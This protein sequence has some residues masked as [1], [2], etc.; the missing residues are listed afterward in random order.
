LSL[1]SNETPRYAGSPIT[2]T[3]KR[4]VLRQ[5]LYA[6]LIGCLTATAAAATDDDR[7]AMNAAYRE[8]QEIM[9][10][11]VGSRQEAIAPA[12]RAF[13]LA[14]QV[15]GTHQTTAA[16]G[17]NYGNLLQ[18][19]PVEARAVLT[20]A[21]E[22]SEAVHGK[23]ALELVDALL[24]LA[25]AAT[26]GRDLTGARAYYSHAL[27]IAQRHEPKD[28]LLQGI[29]TLNLGVTNYNDDKRLEAMRQFRAAREILAR[30]EGTL[31]KIRLATAD[32]W[33]GTHHVA[34]GRHKEAVEPLLAALRTFNEY[35][36]TR[37]TA[38]SNLKMLVEA[39]EAQGLREEATPHVIAVGRLTMTEPV[40]LYEVP[41]VLS[42]VRTPGAAVVSFTVDEQGYPV[43]PVI[44]NAGSDER[45]GATAL[46]TAGK[47]RY[48]PRVV[49]GV[50]VATPG[51]THMFRFRP[52]R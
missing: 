37:L 36:E 18:E 41:P 46:T 42:R 25:D 32:L 7:Q 51:V 35:P 12:R 5:I 20:E 47:L 11:G 31:A 9:A 15:H 48:A 22:I 29:I 52:S 49:D 30:N 38:V 13:E 33:I 17:I 23:D 40:L 45:F 26:A 28:S 39:Y 19:N 16:L 8:Y 21:L 14:K 6:T 44:V 24:G 4:I 2:K 50:P 10:R 43:D 1:V 27:Q 34:S 3:K